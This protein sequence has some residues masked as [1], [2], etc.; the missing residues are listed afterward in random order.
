M[1]SHQTHAQQIKT[2]Q[3]T[4]YLKQ[5]PYQKQEKFTKP[6][7]FRKMPTYANPNL[8]DTQKQITLPKQ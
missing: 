1:T 6:T 8:T 4:T 2:N 7:K 3:T 5:N